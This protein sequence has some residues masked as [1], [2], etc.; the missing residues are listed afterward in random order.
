MGIYLKRKRE[1]KG[2][3]EY[4][5]KYW[6]ETFQIWWEKYTHSGRSLSLILDK[7]RERHSETHHYQIIKSQR[8]RKIWKQQERGLIIYKWSSIR[9]K[10]NFSSG[11]SESTR[12]HWMIHWKCWK[13]KTLTSNSICG[14]TACRNTGEIKTF[15]GTVRPALHE[16]WR[17]SWRL[18][19]KDTRQ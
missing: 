17:G 3:K 9:L 14:K 2:P 12:K 16:C 15:P 8:L 19:W 7:L 1:R 5:K 4:L 18:K 13:N 10:P 11:I 6:Q